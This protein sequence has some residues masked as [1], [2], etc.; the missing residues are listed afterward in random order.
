MITNTDSSCPPQKS[1]RNRLQS[2][3][4]PF[5]EKFVLAQPQLSS[6]KVGAHFRERLWLKKLYSWCGL[7]TTDF[8]QLVEEPAAETVCP[9]FSWP[10]TSTTI[11]ALPDRQATKVSAKGKWRRIVLQNCAQD[12]IWRNSGS[13]FFASFTPSPDPIER[14]P[15]KEIKAS[16]T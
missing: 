3:P 10:S 8:I 13:Y 14:G 2:Q 5:V 4:Q 15:G 12:P 16:A 7:S 6:I 1:G 9:N 11:D